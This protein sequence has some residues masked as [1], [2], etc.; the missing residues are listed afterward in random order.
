MARTI[1]AWN[2]LR[3]V[4]AKK[5]AAMFA[6]RC[7]SIAI[8]VVAVVGGRVGVSQFDLSASSIR[9]VGFHRLTLES[10]GVHISIATQV[11]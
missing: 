4:I 3:R 2:Y 7:V 10:F 8:A 11:I 5:D 1:Y 9:T 6:S